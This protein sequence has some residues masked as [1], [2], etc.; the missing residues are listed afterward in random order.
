M[1]DHATPN[2]PSRDFETTSRFYAQFGFE[3][4]WRDDG[5]MILKRGGLTLEFFPHPDVDPWTSNFSCCLR[6]DDL[7]ALY[8]ACVASGLSETCRG[9]PRLHAPKVEDSGLRIGAL[10]D[11]DGTLLRLIQN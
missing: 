3:Q 2:L 5:W 7:D 1:T 9:H 11:P 8:A 10:I 6:L 4:G